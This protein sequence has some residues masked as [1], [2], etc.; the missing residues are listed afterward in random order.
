MY[1][2]KSNEQSPITNP[3]LNIR[4]KLVQIITTKQPN[5]VL[6]NKTSRIRL[7]VTEEVIVKPRLLV[8]ILALQPERGSG[9]VGKADELVEGIVL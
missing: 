6:V 7:I 8:V 3:N 9:T 1:D 5:R 2:D 4:C